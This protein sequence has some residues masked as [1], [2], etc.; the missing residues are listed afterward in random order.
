MKGTLGSRRWEVLS[1]SLDSWN[2]VLLGVLQVQKE[3]ME[4]T[5]HLWNEKGF[6]KNPLS[7]FMEIWWEWNC[8]CVGPPVLYMLAGMISKLSF[9]VFQEHVK[10]E[11][12]IRSWH[13]DKVWRSSGRKSQGTCLGFMRR[14]SEQP[15]RQN[16]LFL[17]AGIWNK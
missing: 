4:N 9:A 3:K 17:I 13:E 11:E 5:T 7:H 14:G 6:L 1:P 15:G 16:R 2:S 10:R 12:V 8:F